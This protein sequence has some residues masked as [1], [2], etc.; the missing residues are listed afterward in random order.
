MRYTE[1]E[2]MFLRETYS[3][4]PRDFIVAG[5]GNRTWNS[6]QKK[7]WKLALSRDFNENENSFKFD[8]ILKFKPEDCYWIGFMLA[9]GHISKHNNIQINLAVKDAGHLEKLQNYCGFPIIVDKDIHRVRARI[10]DVI[11]IRKIK[12]IFCW[13]TNKTVIPPKIPIL[14]MDQLFSIVIGFIDGDGAIDSRNGIR[15][16]CSISWQN[17][18]NDFYFYLTGKKREF[19]GDYAIM[20]VHNFLEVKNIKKKAISLGLPLMNRKWDRIDLKKI[21]K[22]EKFN[23]VLNLFNSGFSIKEIKNKTGYSNSL[24]YKVYKTNK[25]I[26]LRNHQEEG[27]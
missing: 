15:V 18:L 7:A 22:Y 19:S 27:R 1:K 9:D 13:E 14:K 10:S 16:K 4:Q 12:N 6:I 11:T 8:K 26:I 17:I 3:T 2:E 24:I 21:T 25:Q 23:H 20:T 5:L